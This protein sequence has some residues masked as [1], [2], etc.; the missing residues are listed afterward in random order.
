LGNFTEQENKILMALV[1]DTINYG[2]SEKESLAYIKAR[3][4][5]KEISPNAYYNRKRKVDSGEYSQHWLNF[6]SKTGFVIK[7]KQIIEVIEGLQQDSLKDYLIE[8]SKQPFE[9]RNKNEISKLRY[10]IRE[11]A[12]LLQE[13]YLGTPI[14]AQ[15]KARI[16]QKNVEV[17]QSG[18]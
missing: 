18:K 2:L 15:I 5:G 3:L 16:D 13:L 9:S 17:F 1:S 7:H 12:K 4:G 11:S 10:E 8:K 6:F 14:I